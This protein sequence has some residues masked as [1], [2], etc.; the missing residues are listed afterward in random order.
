M[1]G[2]LGILAIPLPAIARVEHLFHSGTLENEREMNSPTLFDL[3]VP[4]D[5]SRGRENPK[6]KQAFERV[7]KN[8]SEMQDRVRIFVYAC[9]FAGATLEEVAK[10]FDKLP[11]QLSG[12]FSELNH[13]FHVIFDSNRERNGFS[14]YV[15]R[16][17]WVTPKGQEQ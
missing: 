1:H 15:G 8:L 3:S 9:G 10:A 5:I 6:S 12:R 16:R 4:Q 17:E 7:K 11:H 14:V 13:K 2:S